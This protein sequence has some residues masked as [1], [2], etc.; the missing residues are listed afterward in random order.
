MPTIASLGGRVDRHEN[1]G[2]GKIGAETLR[3]SYDAPAS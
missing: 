2:E 3:E 1:I